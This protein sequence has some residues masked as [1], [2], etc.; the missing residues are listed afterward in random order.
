LPQ[1]ERRGATCRSTARAPLLVTAELPRDVYGWAEG[2]RRKHFPPERNKVRAHAT[3]FHALPPSL[4]PELK[5][6]LAE[7]SAEPPPAATIT[8]LMPLG[9]GTAFAIASPELTAIHEEMVERLHGVL[10]A[11]DRQRRKLHVTV[12]NKVTGAEAKALQAELAAG[13]DPRD[14]AF[15]GL[16]LHRYL[17]GRWE[18]AGTWPFR[19]SARGGRH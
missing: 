10:T 7:L 6:M 17:G 5:R 8:G 12:Q 15:A 11:Q 3:L 14:F 4:E 9:G 13:F 16:S 18:D 19:G 1:D 2:L